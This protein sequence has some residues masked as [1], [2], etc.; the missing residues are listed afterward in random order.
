MRRNG[1]N[2][3][4]LAVVIATMTLLVE[5]Y[6]TRSRAE[7]IAASVTSSLKKGAVSP[8]D[9]QN[10]S[11]V[12]LT[13]PLYDRA[14]EAFAEGGYAAAQGMFEQIV[15]LQNFPIEITEDARRK[16]ADCAYFLGGKN[17][18][19]SFNKAVEYYR[20]ILSSYPDVRAGNDLVHYR[21][22]KSYENLNSYRAAGEQFEALATQYPSSLYIQDAFFGM[23]NMMEKEGKLERAI[24]S[25]RLYLFRYPDGKYAKSSCF[26]IGDCYYRLRQTVNADIWFRGAAKK[27][28]D[29]QNLPRE[30]L[31]N[32]GF[33]N[34]QMGRYAEAVSIFSLY[35]SLYPK[36]ES[37]RHVLYSLA[38]ALAGM[39]QT[40]AAMKVFGG[41]M[42]Q[43]PGTR[44][45]RD[46]AISMIDLA[47]EKSGIKTKSPVVFGE[48]H[49]YHD[50]LSAYDYFL[51]KYPQGELTEY[52]LYRK[53]C[54]LFKG[55]R[56]LEAFLNFDR[57]LV[58]NPKGRY[59][60]SGKRYLK[61]MVALVVGEYEKKD[62]HLA[63]ADIYFRSYARHLLVCDDYATCYQMA[64]SLVE[65]GL[66]AESLVLLKELV[67]REKDPNRRDGLIVFA[68]EINRLEG[69]DRDA[70]L[71][72]G[73]GLKNQEIVNRIKR[74]LAR[75]YFLRG[76]WVKAVHNYGDISNSGRSEMT[77]LDFHRYAQALNS[78][79][80][81]EQALSY[82]RQTIKMVQDNPGRYP[83]HL[84]SESYMGIGECLY[85]E[86]NFPAGLP[87]YQQALSGLNERRDQWWV[88]FRLGQ[89][90]TRLNRPELGEKAFAEAK[91]TA[92]TG[93][94]F[95]VKII[96]SWKED[97]LWNEQNRRY[98]E[99]P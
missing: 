78:S 16:L 90:Y 48:G 20:S 94:A 40:A 84:L 53:G 26:A 69:R 99:L 51:A 60:E 38:Y 50:P 44:E 58:L 79:K 64:R 72:A 27:W 14:V 55:N 9:D 18:A 95:V 41:M 83:L 6:R 98:L 93:D 10:S 21:L 49:G 73:G 47:V 23:G 62:N 97:N 31:L 91:A 30:V 8:K 46:S 57:L 45:A 66:Y 19:P 87:M 61:M 54:A 81:Y 70:G 74:D 75:I 86:N 82:Y 96:D 3:I 36:D 2:L 71:L 65:V 15:Q 11:V 80:Q 1:K 25:Y 12:P 52:L 34:Y 59:G 7:D 32:F 39:E 67:R 92:R 22:A 43:F 85:R 28:P 4:I 13:Y 17:G 76:D 56:P 29:L 77:A 89:G 37:S 24:E 63:V 5:G 35:V 42:E 33:H 68:A 88:N